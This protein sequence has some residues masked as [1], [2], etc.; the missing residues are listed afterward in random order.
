[1]LNES[2][3]GVENHAE[4]PLEDRKRAFSMV[5]HCTGLLRNLA[6]NDTLK[7]LPYMIGMRTYT[8]NVKNQIT[9]T[10]TLLQLLDEME[11]Q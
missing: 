10:P 6:A 7:V 8:R 11:I 9:D 4:A 2:I 5:I 1:M 3:N